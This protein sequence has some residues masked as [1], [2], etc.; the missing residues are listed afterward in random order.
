[1]HEVLL[2]STHNLCFHGIIRVRVR[3]RVRKYQYFSVEKK[4]RVI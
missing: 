1:M 4:K 2:I 3:V